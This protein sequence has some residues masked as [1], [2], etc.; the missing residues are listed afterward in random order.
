MSI[1]IKSAEL[2]CGHSAPHTHTV[3]MAPEGDT[4]ASHT[5]H[6]R[7]L[8]HCPYGTR[9]WYN[10]FTHFTH[11]APHTLPIW[12]QRVIQQLHTLHT[13]G[14][15]HTSTY[16]PVWHQRVIEHLHTFHTTG[17]GR[18]GLC[19]YSKYSK[20]GVSLLTVALGQTLHFGPIYSTVN[21]SNR[22]RDFRSTEVILCGFCADSVR[23]L[24]GFAQIQLWDKIS[25]RNW[26]IY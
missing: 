16:S 24:C 15:S 12:Q 17:V 6:N 4:T 23:I 22:F 5:S 3:H 21:R 7:H 8:T 2:I 1:L 20:K 14:T 11:S 18:V 19:S 10:S 25:L 9:G 26:N 13:F